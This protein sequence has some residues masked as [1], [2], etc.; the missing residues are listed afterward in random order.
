[1]EAKG[2]WRIKL[3]GH[4]LPPP[5]GGY[6]R[7]PD[8]GWSRRPGRGRLEVRNSH[9]LGILAICLA[10]V[11]LSG[12]TSP[13]ETDQAIPAPEPGVWKML[14]NDGSIL[15]ITALPIAKTETDWIYSVTRLGGLP[16]R[17]SWVLQVGEG[18]SF[19]TVGTSRIFVEVSAPLDSAAVLLFFPMEK[20]GAGEAVRLVAGPVKD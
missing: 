7:Q 14:G 6:K 8:M 12:V 9:V 10:L 11:I 15:E 18:Y 1:M 3:M 19:R 5:P 13:A 4:H 20:V 16:L 17:C 2:Q